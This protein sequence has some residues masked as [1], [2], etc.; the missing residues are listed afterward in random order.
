MEPVDRGLS[1]FSVFLNRFFPLHRCLEKKKMKSLLMLTLLTTLMLLI[2]ALPIPL[3]QQDEQHHR[4]KRQ[5]G[6][7]YNNGNGNGYGYGG[8][9]G[10]GL[11]GYG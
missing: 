11:F 2:H 4:D 9:Y 6:S 8:G 1:L 5:W 3:D 7:N 10:G